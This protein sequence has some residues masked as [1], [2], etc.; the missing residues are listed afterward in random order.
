MYR[1]I[2]HFKINMLTN[3]YKCTNPGTNSIECIYLFVGVETNINARFNAHLSL[4]ILPHCFIQTNSQ[5][6]TY[7][8][9]TNFKNVLIYTFMIIHCLNSY[10][11]IQ[12]THVSNHTDS[13]SERIN[14]DSVNAYSNTV[15]VCLYVYE[16]SCT[17]HCIYSYLLILV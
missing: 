7:N 11:L 5:L 15:H 1:Q 9:P 16:Y 17:A 13:V 14:T 3:I 4:Q 8:Q 2:I 10:F 6:D 12:K